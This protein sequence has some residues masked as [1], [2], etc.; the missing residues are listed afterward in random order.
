[1][2]KASRITLAGAATAL[3]C[4][5]AAC[6]NNPAPPEWQLN[7]KSGIDRALDAWFAG[8]ARAEA[9]E[10][11]RVRGEI[12]RTGRPALLARVELVRC[13]ARA[14][15]LVIEECT[16]YQ[17]LAQDAEPAERAYATYL[18]GRAGPEDAPLLP[19]QHRALAAPGATPASDL[20]ALQRMT[21]PLSTLVGAAV[22]LQRG[23][24]GPAVVAL[25]VDTASA[26]GWRRPLLA[27]LGVQLR[28]AEGAGDGAAAQRIRRRIGL[29][30]GD[31]V[32]QR[33]NPGTALSTPQAT[34]G[35]P[36]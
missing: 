4:A 18:N 33:A 7:A 15:S 5:L 28:Q 11:E 1:M 31:R 30:E 35:D 25:A 22:S 29:V 20:A 13:A 21:D 2:T 24:A 27:W 17:A 6:A 16:A 12:A 9:Q 32:V 34:P 14:A 36:S 23:R 10:F 19:E 8:D 26:Q 3:A